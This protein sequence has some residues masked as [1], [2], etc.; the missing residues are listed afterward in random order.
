MPARVAEVVTLGLELPPGVR[1][2][3]AEA[4]HQRGQL[5]A[6]LH[7]AQ[8]HLNLQ[9]L[10]A[11]LPL[12]KLSLGQLLAMVGLLGPE[13]VDLALRVPVWSELKTCL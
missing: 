12:V 11:P 4:I 3:V 1:P 6:S 7:P 10:S 8:V 9:I 5:V 2:T 13:R